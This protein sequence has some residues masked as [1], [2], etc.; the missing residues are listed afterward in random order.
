MRTTLTVK[1]HAT[2]V[3]TSA[4]NVVERAKKIV[5][6]A[7]MI[8]KEESTFSVTAFVRE[9]RNLAEE[10]QMGDDAD[11]DGKVTWKEG[12]GGLA[13]ASKHM[14]FMMKGEKMG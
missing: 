14:G 2:H 13:Q 5:A 6:L 9:L 8:A 4:N 10:L 11:G 7:E 1:L 12:E 3:A